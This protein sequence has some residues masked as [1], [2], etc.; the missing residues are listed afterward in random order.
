MSFEF[1][2]YK[3][4]TPRLKQNVLSVSTNNKKQAMRSQ[5]ITDTVKNLLLDY[6]D[7]NKFNINVYNKLN[8]NEKLIVDLLLKKSGMDDTLGIRITNEDAD[9][10]IDRYELLRGEVIAGND[11]LEVRK[12]LR[13]IVLDLVRLGSLPLRQSYE[14]LLELCILDNK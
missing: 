7:H 10:L 6:R 9:R 8:K 5:I 1:G 2:K 14:L 4:S 3:I 13:K 11:S 12:E